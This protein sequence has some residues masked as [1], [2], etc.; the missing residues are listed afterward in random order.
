MATQRIDRRT[1]LVGTQSVSYIRQITLDIVITNCKPNTRMYPFFDGIRVDEFVTPNGS[2]IGSACT[3]NSAG[4]F[5]GKFSIPGFRFT[6]GS[7]TFT[8]SETQ[9]LVSGDMLG[10]T[11]GSAS[12]EFTSTGIRQLFQETVNTTN[13]T[14]VENVIRR[15]VVTFQPAPPPPVV[16]APVRTVP[17]LRNTG[18]GGRGGSDPVAQ[19]FD[20]YGQ[21]G[22]RFITAIDLYFNTKDAAI[23]VMV[24]IR[25]MVNGYPGPTM[26]DPAAFVSLTPDMVSVSNDASLPTRFYFPRMVYLPEDREYCFVILANTNKYNIFTSIISER[27]NETGATVFEQVHLGSIFKS[28]NNTTWTADQFED[29]KFTIYAAKFDTDSSAVLAMAGSATPVV[30]PS[31]VLSTVSGTNIITAKLTHKHGFDVGSSVQIAIDTLGT[32]N[33]ITGVNLLGTNSGTWEVTSVLDEYSFRFA[34]LVNATSTG[35]ILTG[36][37]LKTIH[38]DSGG[39]GYSETSPP[40]VIIGGPGTGA[41]ATATVIGGALA[42]ITVTNP[43]TGYTTNP[44]VTLSTAFGSGASVQSDNGL[45]ISMATNRIAHSMNPAISNFIPQGTAIE[46]SLDTVLGNFPGGNIANYSTGNSV[47]F[48]IDEMKNLDQNVLLCSRANEAT[49]LSNGRSTKVNLVL[50]SNNPNV[51]PVVDINQSKVMFA[52]NTVNN[53]L[54][55][56]KTALT[57]FGSLD[58]VVVVGGGTGYSV[59]P[60]VAIV[61]AEGDTGSGATATAVIS[62]GVV[63]QINVALPGSGYIKIPTVTITGTNTT[64][65]TAV[66]RLTGFNTEIS[67]GLGRAAARYV[68]KPQTLATVSNGARVIVNA[69]SSENTSIEVYLR[70]T[71]SAAGLIHQDQNWLQMTCDV[72]RNAS[73]SKSEFL[74]YEFYLN[75]ISP[76][77]VFD[78]KIV[79]GSTVPYDAPV[80]KNY[81]AIMIT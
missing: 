7:K 28:Q 58:S 69:Y 29:V 4:K 62:G 81:R 51:S 73:T 6:T 18:S 42:Y 34:I 61:P 44:T 49:K 52:S 19:S 13:T 66:A 53:Q 59:A 20:T 35:P 15:E 68:C 55:D 74:D 60:A 48:D 78:I 38:V 33:G 17:I 14:T 22:G 27:S 8:M 16:P 10:S 71:S 50:T 3:T 46:A 43:G 31:S 64:P 77:D 26:A 37:R 2:A 21:A 80:I 65:A 76:F 1:D 9:D 23:P 79:L 56:V 67:P 36:G 57:P 45:R 30:V 40:S 5:V 63:T 70:T 32:Y 12:A 39:S 25:E 11:I 24:E 47:R 72:A 54:T 41:S 75:K